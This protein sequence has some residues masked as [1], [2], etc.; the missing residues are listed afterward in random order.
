MRK[1]PL[2][3]CC[4]AM[5][6]VQMAAAQMPQAS[7]WVPAALLLCVGLGLLR[8]GRRLPGLCLAAGAI[9]GG[10][11]F[12]LTLLTQKLPAEQWIGQTVSITAQVQQAE[13]SYSEDVVRATLH[14]TQADGK[15]VSFTCICD[16]LPSCETGQVIR[17]RFSFSAPEADG[18]RMSQYADG[19]FCDAEYQSDFAE[20]EASGGVLRF[21]YQLRMQLSS[22]IRRYLTLDEGGVLAAMTVGDRRFIRDGLNRT[23]RTAGIPH[24]LV[25]S[26]LHL[27]LLCG[28]IPLHRELRLSRAVRG[29]SGILLA[30][31][32]MGVTGGTPSILRAGFAVVLSGLGLLLDEPPD[33]VTSLALSGALYSLSN[34]YTI[35]DVSFLLSFSAT[36]GVLFGASK[37]RAF[38]RRYPKP[39]K[40]I[41][42]IGKTLELVLPSLCASCATLPVLVLCGM[43]VSAVSVLTNLATLWLIPPIL[44]CG[45][46]A[47]VLGSV[48]ILLPL[49]R[50][51]ALAGG[52]LVRLLN[53]LV[54]LF[55]AV[56]GASLHAETPYPVAVLCILGLFW[57]AARYFRLPRERTLACGAGLLAFAFLLHAGL[58]RDLIQVAQVG[59]AY[60]PATVILQQGQAAVLYRGGAYNTRKIQEYLEDRNISDI[61]LLIDLRMDPTSA[62]T[63]EADTCA[64]FSEWEKGTYRYTFGALEIQTVVEGEGGYVLLQGGDCT[65]AVTTG[66]QPKDAVPIAADVFLAASG[67]PG[68][69]AEASA[70]LCLS[71]SYPWLADTRIP[72]LYFGEKGAS[73][74]L[75]PKSGTQ[76]WP[77]RLTG[78]TAQGE[79]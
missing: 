13:S 77:L 38:W 26:G 39:P 47:A 25:I 20:T 68:H 32:M 60:T 69:F 45:L 59:N 54:A 53:G 51:A 40:R 72:Q 62:C 7:F 36:A 15:R 30:L 74:W 6:A 79:T 24:V 44:I 48:P 17:G 11:A 8:A 64:A 16:A 43:N 42:R 22:N 33:P 2:C 41:R 73:V 23:Y 29:L 4:V 50:A 28:L 63:L 46:C 58:S 55:A 49:Y 14:V 56:P 75:R 9:L 66:T 18:Y 5:L 65:L 35:Y 70:A 52:I 71:Q 34:A 61:R 37:V 12:G 57:L 19:A 1:R 67:N 21:F 27:S 3:A 31:C 10:L 78:I 76:H